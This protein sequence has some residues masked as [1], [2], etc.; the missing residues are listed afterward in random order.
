MDKKPE[1]YPVAT[2]AGGCFWC[3]ESEFRGLDGV[4]Y[5]R[6]GYIGGHLENPKYEDTHDSKSGHAE[7]VEVTFDPSKISYRQLLEHFF[8][9]AHDPTQLNRQGPDVGTQYRSAIF[10]HDAEQ[11][12]IAEDLIAELTEK[13]KFSNPIVTTL[14]PAGTFWEAEGYHQQY[15]EKFEKKNGKPHINDWLKRQA[16]GLGIKGD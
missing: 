10:Y 13:K 1:N 8:L 16:D 3:T 9:K 14:E 4:L 6:V 11:K 2:L 12:K 7:A 5:T 15:Y